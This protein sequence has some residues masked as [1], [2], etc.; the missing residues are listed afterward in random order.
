MRADAR[1]THSGA[2]RRPRRGSAG[3]GAAA[4]AAAARPW[5]CDVRPGRELAR[6]ALLK[7]SRVG[8]RAQGTG[9]YAAAC[10]GAG[11]W[12]YRGI[13]GSGV[14]RSGDLRAQRRRSVSRQGGAARPSSGARPTGAERARHQA[15]PV[16]TSAARLPPRSAREARAPARHTCARGERP[17]VRAGAGGARG[18][19][20]QA[21]PR[22]AVS[23]AQRARGSRARAR[24][25]EAHLEG[26][27][28][29]RSND[30]GANCLSPA[31]LGGQAT[32]QPDMPC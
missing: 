21:D 28:A 12:S 23:H 27:L 2:K 29:S 15:W 17:L 10:R 30:S 14:S 18:L 8:V 25:R 26:T 13:P 16:L 20:A 4:A 3:G 19:R 24:D 7:P 1:L 11:T 9:S 32:Y 31:Y 6:P 22:R 5:R